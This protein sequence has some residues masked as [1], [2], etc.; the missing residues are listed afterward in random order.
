MTDI[1]IFKD[2]GV[3]IIESEIGISRVMAEDE[4][5]NFILNPESDYLDMFLQMLDN[6]AENDIAV[7]VL[8][9]PHYLPSWFKNKYP[10]AVAQN[11]FTNNDDMKRLIKAYIDAVVPKIKDKPAVHS[12]CLTNEPGCQFTNPEYDLPRYRDYLKELFG[13]DISSLNEAYNTA[14]SSFEDIS[15]PEYTLLY[16]P[17]KN[18]DK[19]AE[20]YNFL[21]FNDKSFA[22][23][24]EWMYGLVKAYMP[25]VLVGTKIMQTFDC[26]DREWRRRFLWRGTDPEMMG[27]L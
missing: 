22:E 11:Y 6:A 1:P 9:S 19:L 14:Y 24:H 7:N 4:N 2:M 3:N 12:I 27:G 15:F 5:G 18:V 20:I 21:N 13:G 16:E 8:L 17:E 10:E 25:D 23:F 26:D